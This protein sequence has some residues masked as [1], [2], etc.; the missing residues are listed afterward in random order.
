MKVTLDI[1]DSKAAFLIELLESLDYVTVTDANFEVPEWH[2]Q[3]VMDR[4][5]DPNATFIDEEELFKR[6][7]REFL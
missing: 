3:I 1:E 4:V 5:N 6:L 7:E 2:K